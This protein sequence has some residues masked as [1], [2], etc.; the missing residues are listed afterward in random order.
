[1]LGRS[2]LVSGGKRKDVIM[3]KLTHRVDAPGDAAVEPVLAHASNKI[4]RA[5][6]QI[7]DSIISWA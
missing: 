7:S 4:H 2:L 6:W 1:M 5:H 3:R